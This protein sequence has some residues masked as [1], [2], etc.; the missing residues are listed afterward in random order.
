MLGQLNS[1]VE[2]YLIAQS[3][4]DCVINTSIANATVRALIQKFPQA[5]GNIDLESTT[6]SFFKQMRFVKR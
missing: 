6:W 1:V 5:V 2:T 3:Q 4:R